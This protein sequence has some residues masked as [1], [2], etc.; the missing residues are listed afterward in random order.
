MLE[1]LAE[2]GVVFR[3]LRLER[4]ANCLAM[5]DK[6]RIRLHGRNRCSA[7]GA[8]LRIRSYLKVSYVLTP[9]I[10]RALKEG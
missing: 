1:Y 10:R 5:Q 4:C 7:C 6:R 8:S 9:D 2:S 3:R